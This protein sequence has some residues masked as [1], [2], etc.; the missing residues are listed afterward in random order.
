MSEDEKRENRLRLLGEFDDQK[1]EVAN[2]QERDNRDREAFAKF[3]AFMESEDAPSITGEMIH[4][5]DVQYA[6]PILDV[7]AAS[8]RRAELVSAKKRLAEL[9]QRCRAIGIGLS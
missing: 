2:L 8:I 1:T 6:L 7:N 3:S 4:F 9:E 5:G